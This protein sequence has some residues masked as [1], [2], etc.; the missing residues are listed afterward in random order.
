[1]PLCFR[2]IFTFSSVLG[3]AKVAPLGGL[4]NSHLEET[5]GPETREE[6]A[7]PIGGPGEKRTNRSPA[8][9]AG[10]NVNQT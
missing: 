4:Y 8:L 5:A 1:M 10:S 9:R 2:F 3:I 6:A 7:G